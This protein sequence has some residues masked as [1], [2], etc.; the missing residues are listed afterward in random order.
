ME[1]EYEAT[2]ADIDVEEM[3]LKLTES[4][5]RLARPEYN[6]KRTVY[7]LPKQNNVAGEFA[8]IRDE[9]DK[10]TLS[11]KAFDGDEIHNQRETCITVN[12]FEEAGKLLEILGCKLKAYQE[13][14]RELWILD[15]VEVTIDTWPF[16][17]PYV[18]VEGKSEEVVRSVSE[19]LGFDWS[20]AIFGGVDVLYSKKYGVSKDQINDQTPKIIF[21]MENPFLS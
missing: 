10:I 13:T 19:K 11:V 14:R 1:I 3:R 6:Q 17:E 7:V 21:E 9:G 2:F 16:L 5:A 4:G 15:D 18:E 8:R 12:S 20:K